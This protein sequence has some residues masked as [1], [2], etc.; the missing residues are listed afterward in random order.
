MFWV[1]FEQFTEFVSEGRAAQR[2]GRAARDL[3][4]ASLVAPPGTFVAAADVKVCPDGFE[5]HHFV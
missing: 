1:G 3:P 4:H 5:F 2:C